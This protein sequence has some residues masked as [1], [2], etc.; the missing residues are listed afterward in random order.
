MKIQTR[1]QRSRRGFTF[2]PVVLVDRRTDTLSSEWA[3]K[4]DE[5]APEVSLRWRIPITAREVV[6]YGTKGG[7]G[8]FGPRDQRINAFTVAT[9]LGGVVRQE[10][11]VTRPIEPTG[12]AVSLD[13]SLGFD[14][15]I[16]AMRPGDV[17]GLFEGETGAALS[18]IEV[19]GKI[20]PDASAT[21]AI[22]RGDVD[23]DKR[24]NITDAIVLLNGL[25]QGVGPLC[26]EEAGD[27]NAD[28]RLNLT[29]AIHILLWRYRGGLPP[30]D[31]WLGCGRVGTGALSC[32][33]EACP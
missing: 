2:S 19:I 7:D 17:V 16:V 15:L 21:M 5:Q 14:V 6:V 32:D 18:E 22:I 29:D 3:A 23:C 13:E 12:T 24:V 28:G 27:A 26:C 31:P 4:A 8:R 30:A 1:F 20:I 9:Y 11:R 10:V 33:E 25:F